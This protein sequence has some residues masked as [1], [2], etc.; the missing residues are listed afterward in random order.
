M[1]EFQV[2]IVFWQVKVSDSFLIQSH[3]PTNF[4]VLLGLGLFQFFVIVGL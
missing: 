3:V 2:G 4:N 1:H